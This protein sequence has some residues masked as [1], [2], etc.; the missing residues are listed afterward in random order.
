M[1]AL[2]ANQNVETAPRGRN[3]YDLASAQQ[4]WAG[5]LC[6]KNVAGFLIPWD[7]VAATQFVG[8]VLEDALEGAATQDVAPVH[9]EGFLIK[10][11]PIASAVQGSVGLEVHCT[12][13][14]PLEDCVLAGA[15]VSRGIG[16]IIRFRSS[17]DCDIEVYSAAEW[18][19]RS[20]ALDSIVALTDSSGGTG[21][22]T[23]A[24][25][26]VAMVAIDGSGMTAAQEAE[27]NGTMVVIRNALSS[28]SDKINEVLSI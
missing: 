8:L 3:V 18:S 24:A 26:D 15:A 11:I 9:D 1:A 13:D 16:R 17:S 19:A 22:D 21:S 6:G 5:G 4:V 10:N 12:T 27:Y 23:L 7:N 14:N 28:L 20:G 2:T 25:L